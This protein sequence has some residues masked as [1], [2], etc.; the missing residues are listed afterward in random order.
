MAVSPDLNSISLTANVSGI[1]P[2]ANGGTG[3]ASGTS[4]G[5]AYYSASG[6][7]ASSALLTANGVLIGGG[8][9]AAPTSTFV[10]FSGPSSSVKT[11]ILPNAGDTI[12][13]LGQVNAFTKQQ[14]FSSATLTSS[15]NSI[16]WDLN[17]AQVAIHTATENTTLATPTNMQTGFTYIF[18]FIQASSAKTLA[19]GGAYKWPN[20]VAPTVS[21]G[22]GAVDIMS[23]WTDGT[24][25]YGTYQQAFA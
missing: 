16:A 7:I 24:N 15:S 20:G 2:V 10:G 25:M 13:C 12:A 19:F 23:F 3:L 5:V 8:A 1:L 22:S 14:G 9:G 4:G 6:T 17:S 18:K 21:T 11:F